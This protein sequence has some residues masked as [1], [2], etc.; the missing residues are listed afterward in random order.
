MTHSHET[1]GVRDLRIQTIELQINVAGS[2]V[3]L[4]RNT[5]DPNQFES[6]K[7]K[8]RAAYEEAR[9]LLQSAPMSALQEATTREQLRLLDD[10]LKELEITSSGL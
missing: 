1:E 6:Y 3:L 9:S 4:A 5:K 2:Y 10:R 7:H 8:A